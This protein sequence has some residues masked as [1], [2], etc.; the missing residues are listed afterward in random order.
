[1][2]GPHCPCSGNR[3]PVPVTASVF[4]Q[5]VSVKDSFT[6]RHVQPASCPT[7]ISRLISPTT[8]RPLFSDAPASRL[9]VIGPII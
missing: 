9:I 4:Y 8:P 6:P 7:S 3:G 1:M 5:E 2:E